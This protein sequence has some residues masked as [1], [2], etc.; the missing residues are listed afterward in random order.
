MDAEKKQ[1]FFLLQRQNPASIHSFKSFLTPPCGLFFLKG[2]FRRDGGGGDPVPVGV[3]DGASHPARPYGRLF[4]QLLATAPPHLP[5]SHLEPRLRLPSGLFA[6]RAA[7][8]GPLQQRPPRGLLSRP[9]TLLLDQDPP[10]VPRQHRRRLLRWRGAA[11]RRRLLPLLCHPRL[12]PWRS[13]RAHPLRVCPRDPR[14]LR[15]A[16][17]RHQAFISCGFFFFFF[18]PSSPCFFPHSWHCDDPRWPISTCSST[19]T[20]SFTILIFYFFTTTR[21]AWQTSSSIVLAIAKS[22]VP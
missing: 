7:A 14:P 16:Q 2:G 6:S 22:G 3:L 4:R 1:N 8:Q 11:A 21:A 10:Q 19:F 9:A 20:S 18:S 13:R 15:K 17:R 5:A 12:R